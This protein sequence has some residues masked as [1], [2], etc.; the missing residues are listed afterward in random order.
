MGVLRLKLFIYQSLSPV[1]HVESFR[2]NIAIADMHILISSILDVRNSFQNTNVP[3][4]ERVCVSPPPYYTE[5]FEISYTNVP[6]TRDDGSFC[7]QCLN[8]IKGTKPAVRKRNR[9]LDTVVTILK[10]KKITIDHAVY[11][12]FFSDVTVYYLTVYTDDVLNTTNSKTSF[13]ENSC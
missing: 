1:A 11:I 9:L 7:I 3:I 13:L 8:G 4:I 5:W 10:Y 2:I 6:L 12:K